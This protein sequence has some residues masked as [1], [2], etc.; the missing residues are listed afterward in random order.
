MITDRQGNAVTGASHDAVAFYD[1][2]LSAFNC[3]RGD[4]IALVDQAIE[5]APD[6]AMAYLMKAYFFGLATE[7]EALAEVPALLA[8]AKALPL[9]AREASHLA[10]LEKLA[11]N[12]WSASANA[13]DLHNLTYP[14]DLLAIQA[15][16]LM[17]FFR[18]DAR[19]LRD[20]I[21]RVLPQWTAAIPG[22]SFLLGFQSFGLEE[23]GDY[24]KAEE[25]GRAALTLEPED[26]WAHHAVAH[27]MEM[28]GRF[29]DGIGWMIAREGHWAQEDNFFQVHNW[30]HRC[31]YHFELGEIDTIL[32]LYD[33]PIREG[34]SGVAVDL[35]D[36]SALLW[37][38]SLAGHDVGDRWQELSETWD[39]VADGKL[40]SF[41]D[42]HG[43]MAYLGAGR[44]AEVERI[45]A[46]YRAQAADDGEMPRWIRAYGLPLVEGFA[47]FW[48]GEHE[49][50]IERLYASRHIASGFGGSHAQRDV[51]DWTL[52]ESAL[53]A[54]KT[55]LA[56]GLAQER[57]ALK[58][59]SPINLGFLERARAAALPS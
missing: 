40:Y 12:A 44:E 54:G 43:V 35:V 2:A 50:A 33:G 56:E 7:P 16:H 3:Y 5:A 15:G 11:A 53:R 25:A 31:L 17:D 10:A 21:N 14:R 42:L 20:R 28:Q 30:W 37:R 9:N 32:S 13:L 46:S 51:I 24:T 39:A 6:F 23:A 49:A 38:L 47:A 41:N 22:Y 27:V 34:R 45:L 52:T 4:P 59:N 57:L 58:P 29:E 26:C 1:Q 55:D 48:R 18:A 19:N 8:K 36:A